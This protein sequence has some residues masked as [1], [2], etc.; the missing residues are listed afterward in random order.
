MGSKLKKHHLER[1]HQAMHFIHHTYLLLSVCLVTASPGLLCRAVRPSRCRAFD[2][3]ADMGVER[4]KVPEVC[5][6]TSSDSG[7][8]L[9]HGNMNHV[10]SQVTEGKHRGATLATSAQSAARHCTRCS[11]SDPCSEANPPWSW[12]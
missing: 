12:R 4:P 11:C 8:T 1:Q 9:D 10:A 5:G 3:F 7:S 2:H 6:K